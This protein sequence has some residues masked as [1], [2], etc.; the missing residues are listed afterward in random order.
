MKKVE[1]P[2]YK[3]ILTY[4]GV[5][6]TYYET[7]YEGHL[8]YHLYADDHET[9]NPLYNPKDPKTGPSH[10]RSYE[11][12]ITFS[13]GDK[14]EILD[15]DNQSLIG[16][17]FTLGNRLLARED[18]FRFGKAYPEE[19]IELVDW[20]NL[21]DS[22][23]RARL[24]KVVKS[25]NL[26]G[27]TFDPVHQGHLQIINE[28]H[29]NCDKLLISVGNNWTKK[30]PPIFSLYERINSVKAITKNLLNTEVLDWAK[31]ED[32][33]STFKVAEKIKDIYGFYPKIVVGSDNVP[34][35]SKWK[36]WNK[37]KN[38]EFIVI[39]RKGIASDLTL[40]KDLK[41]QIIRGHD[42]SSSTE[43]REQG[44]I[45]LIP[46]AAQDCLDLRKVKKND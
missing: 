46:K 14:I 16:K 36:H 39:E 26:Y 29:Y 1:K 4:N 2:V 19:K 3:K 24:H 10:Y 9:V 30:N 35:L 23:T 28:V 31:T 15:C 12:I 34:Q 22:K 41:H 43:I 27:G 13:T 6:D 25:V 7:G 8:L 11:G 18:N 37:L 5:L 20:H 21:F 44:K 17:T 42:D 40:L 38:L 45:E 33:S 32:T